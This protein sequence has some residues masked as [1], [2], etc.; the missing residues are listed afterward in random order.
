[1]LKAHGLKPETI[2]NVKKWFDNQDTVV[3][4]SVAQKSQMRGL[5]HR[6]LHDI[7]FYIEN[8]QAKAAELLD[9]IEKTDPGK[10]YLKTPGGHQL[11]TKEGGTIFDVKPPEGLVDLVP[12]ALGSP[13]YQRAAEK[14]VHFAFKYEDP[15][16]IGGIKATS[17]S[18]Q[19]T[20]KMGSTIGL[21][22]NEVQTGYGEKGKRYRRLPDNRTSA[23]RIPEDGFI[24]RAQSGKNSTGENHLIQA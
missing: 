3:A 24:L 12:E 1:P 14:Y 19:A 9:L 7:D 18:E 11:I 17:L 22:E 20:R 13:G 15:V 16:K 2:K 8:P 4:G 5:P 10:V 23:Y 6:E 21:R